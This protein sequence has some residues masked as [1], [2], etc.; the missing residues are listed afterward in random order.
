MESMNMDTWNL[1]YVHKIVPHLNN[2]WANADNILY[3]TDKVLE[4]L[5]LLRQL[6]IFKKFSI[7]FKK[8]KKSIF[9]WME[10]G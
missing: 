9:L 7:D 8:K 6:L 10:P 5:L 3:S 1:K 2:D 4:P